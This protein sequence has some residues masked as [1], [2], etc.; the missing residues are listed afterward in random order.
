[1]KIT[2]RRLK[3]LIREALE[4]TP[5]FKNRS[6]GKLEI[7]YTGPDQLLSG[8]YIRGGEGGE[9]SIMI[10]AEGESTNLPSNLIGYHDIHNNDTYRI[11]PSLGIEDKGKK[12]PSQ[13]VYRDDEVYWY[14]IPQILKEKTGV[15]IPEG[16]MESAGAYLDKKAYEVMASHEKNPD[17]DID[18]RLTFVMTRMIDG[19]WHY[20]LI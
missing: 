3:L 1:M 20:H 6:V 11:D 15:V 19:S 8:D 2:R 17:Y 9:L 18:G 5:I 14:D 12:L 10:H 7:Y 16:W 4:V 13:E